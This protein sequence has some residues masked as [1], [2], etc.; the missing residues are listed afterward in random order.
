VGGGAGSGGCFLWFCLGGGGG[1]GGGGCF[2]SFFV[3]RGGGR[4]GAH[5]A[6][7]VSVE[8]VYG[9]GVFGGV[10]FFTGLGGSGLRGAVR[11][12][13]LDLLLSIIGCF[14]SPLSL[15]CEDAPSFYSLD[16]FFRNT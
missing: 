6:W 9:G 10:F 5:G 15:S 1:G 12:G 8:G 3:G 4:A 11:F 2:Y 14:L 13:G 7:A 16:A